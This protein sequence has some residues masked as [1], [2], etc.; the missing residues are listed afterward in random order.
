MPIRSASIGL[1]WP[2][3]AGIRMTRRPTTGNFTGR[4]GNL[5]RNTIIGPDYLTLDV[6][7]SKFVRIQR[8]KIEGFAEAFNVT[9]RVNFGSPTGNIRSGTFGKPTALASGAAPRQVELGFR[10]DF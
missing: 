2:S 10:L 8:M 7:V 3:L 1:I 9:N 5:G 6:R 4:V